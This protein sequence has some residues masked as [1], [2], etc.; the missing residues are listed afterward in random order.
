MDLL[1]RFIKIIPTLLT[2]FILAVAVWIMAVTSNDPVKQDVFPGQVEIEFIG[3]N[4]NLVIMEE[5]PGTIQLTLNAPQSIW[6]TL[7][8]QKDVVRA[9][10]DLSGL[11]AGVHVLPVD[12]QINIRPVRVVSQSPKT[13]EI[14]L[15]R[16]VSAEFPVDVQVQGDPAI[17]FQA[18]MLT[19]DASTVK[20]I[21]PESQASRVRKIRAVLDISGA[22][23]TIVR[24]IT[25]QA[26]DAGEV[27]VEGLTIVPSVVTLTQPIKQR[28]G[29]RSVV[30]N[31]VVSGQVAE[32][33]R[34]TNISVFPP[35]I[36]VYSADP[37]IV[38]NLPG[39][40]ET[41]PLDLT[42]AKDDIDVFMNLNLPFG[43]SVVGDQNT[44]LV[45]VGIAAIESSL[46]FSNMPVEVV[47]LSPGFSAQVAPELVTVI[48]GGPLPILELLTP[49]SIR[50]KVDVTGLK[51]GLHSLVPVVE[52][53][54]GDL[55]V[56]SILPA[57]VDVVISRGGTTTPKP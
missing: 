30:V 8:N 45:R 40:V 32:G 57:T 56:Q 50:V 11:E 51:E 22:Q 41:L 18:G 33:Y 43:V 42:G 34:L 52:L 55:R 53:A 38:K 26:V 36:T 14:T 19:K 54:V 49:A 17:G 10:V 23:Q 12:I 29:Y 3:Q 39:Y 2:A 27:L 35:A 1:R 7:I 44:V 28:F 15:E 31:V 5:N 21:G 46:P 37:D 6:T 16:L 20:I 47:G 4:P 13:V 24:T 25:L 48:V 9:V